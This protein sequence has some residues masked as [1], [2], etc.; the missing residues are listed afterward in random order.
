[1][2]KARNK[3]RLPDPDTTEANWEHDGGAVHPHK[4]E[5]P[6]PQKPEVDKKDAK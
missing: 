4:E 5:E 3:P 6:A 1:M 2:D